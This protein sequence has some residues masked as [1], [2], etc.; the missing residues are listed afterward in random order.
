[1]MPLFQVTFKYRAGNW[2]DH[3]PGVSLTIGTKNVDTASGK[4]SVHS[5]KGF[6]HDN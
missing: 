3:F 4:G 6:R 5:N 2:P 1:M